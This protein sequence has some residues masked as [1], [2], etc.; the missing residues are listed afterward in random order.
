MITF[1]CLA[2]GLVYTDRYDIGSGFFSTSVEYS[3]FLGMGYYFD[4]HVSV[5]STKV[6]LLY[7]GDEIIAEGKI[8]CNNGVSITEVQA[9]F[10]EGVDFG[11]GIVLPKGEKYRVVVPKDAL[12][13][14]ADPSRTND[15]LTYDFEVPAFLRV[16]LTCPRDTAVNRYPDYS[17]DTEVEPFY[18]AAFE[19]YVEGEFER[20]F[21]CVARWDWGMGYAFPALGNYMFYKDVHYTFILPAGSIYALFR[22]DITNDELRCDFVGGYVPAVPEPSYFWSNFCDMVDERC[23][24]EVMFLYPQP[25]RLSANPMVE[26]Y[27]DDV[28]VS[29]VVPT[30]D[31]V[32]PN[33]INPG[34]NYPIDQAWRLKADFGGIPVPKGRHKFACA[35][36]ENSIFFDDGSDRPNTRVSESFDPS[37]IIELGDGQDQRADVYNLQGIRVLSGA[38]ATD[39]KTLPAGIYIRNGQKVRN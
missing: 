19:M 6:A 9:I 5:D 27:V 35:I 1:S 39:L 10:H 36:R 37:S 17:F 22:E 32:D 25:I 31:I 11:D 12:S 7:H 18:G 24:G 16:W 34:R 23:I 3:P 26:Y 20:T 38:T 33:E 14:L 13:S 29:E 4:E 21:P 28:L 2:S 30:I 15:E 8:R